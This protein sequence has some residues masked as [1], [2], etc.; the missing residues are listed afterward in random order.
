MKAP[1]RIQATCGSWSLVAKYQAAK[2]APK[3]VPRATVAAMGM[4]MMR[5]TSSP[6]PPL[7]RNWLTKIR[8]RSHAMARYCA[9]DC[10]ERQGD[11]E[12]SGLGRV[13]IRSG[14]LFV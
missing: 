6:V 11:S 3:E 2:P 12:A 7:R 13:V 1:H 10:A 4:T 8:Q 5:A 14:E 9:R